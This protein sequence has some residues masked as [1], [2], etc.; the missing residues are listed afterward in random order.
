MALY[1]MKWSP[2]A[3]RFSRFTSAPHLRAVSIES[4]V[5][6]ETAASRDSVSEWSNVHAAR[7]I[8]VFVIDIIRE[9][10]TELGASGLNGGLEAL[11]D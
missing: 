11:N 10:I 7:L 8:T 1:V 9:F 3:A 2:P 6:F 4:F 5:A